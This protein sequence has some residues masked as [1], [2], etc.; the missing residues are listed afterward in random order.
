LGSFLAIGLADGDDRARII[1][2]N[3]GAGGYFEAN[4]FHGNQYNLWYNTDNASS[5]RLG[6]YYDGADVYFFYS[7]TQTRKAVGRQ[8][9]RP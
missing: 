2:G 4:Y 6:L 1:R 5:G 3:I 8:S 9:V 7:Q